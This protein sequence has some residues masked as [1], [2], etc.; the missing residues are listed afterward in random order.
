MDHCH[1]LGPA[2]GPDSARVMF[3]GEAPGH[4]GAARTG[5]PFSGD[6]SGLRF[7]RLLAAAG[8]PREEVFVTN[9]VLCNPLREGRNRPPKGSEIAACTPWLRAQIDA[10]DPALVVTLGGV[11]L[12][13]ARLIEPHAFVL[14]ADAGQALRW[15]GR[16]LVP[17]CHPSPRTAVRRSF[18]RQS[19]D[20]RRLGEALRRAGG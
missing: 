8:L 9:A 6:Q 17:L 19:E 18:A 7:E 11:A 2:N 20:F 16:T 10:V 3:I 4:L 15:Y 5:V 14:R 1:V 13:A 12:A